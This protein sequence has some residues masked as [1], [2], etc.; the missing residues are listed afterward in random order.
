MYLPAIVQRHVRARNRHRTEQR[1]WYRLL[2]DPVKSVFGHLWT[3]TR[4]FIFANLLKTQYFPYDNRDGKTNGN[5]GHERF[6]G[7]FQ[8]HPTRRRIG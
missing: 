6:S 7:G 1:A 2:R 3:L 5:G 8:N 4:H